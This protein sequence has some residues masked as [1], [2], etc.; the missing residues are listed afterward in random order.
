MN[1][2]LKL[3]FPKETIQQVVEC[4]AA[5][6]P[7]EVEMHLNTAIIGGW[8]ETMTKEQVELCRTLHG[9]YISKMGY[10]E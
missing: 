3:G 10:E 1:S 4:Y 8:K 6:T 5:E 2:L 7:S 9:D